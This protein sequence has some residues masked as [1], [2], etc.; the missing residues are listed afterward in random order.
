[1]KKIIILI[2]HY[3][4]LDGLKS[5][6]MSIRE[7]FQ[8]DVLIVDDG[9]QVKPNEEELKSIYNNGNLFLEL[10]PENLGVGLATNHGL[11]KITSWEYELTGRLDCGDKVYPNKFAQQINYLKENPDVKLLGTWVNMVDMEGNLLFTLKH[12]ITYPEIKKKI[13]LNS[14]FVNSSVI[15][16]TSILEEIGLF[17]EEYQ[18]NGEDYAF[19]FNV[20]ERF[21]CENL[22]EVLLD[23]EVN[24][25]SL[26]SLGR[27]DQVTARINI[28]KEKFKWGFY[29]IYGLVRSYIL[30]YISRDT[31]TFF[32]KFLHKK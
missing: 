23:Y 1:M 25:N 3:N 14:T 20:I 27:K 6:L 12:P 5:S 30:L 15:Y 16:Y 17:P 31:T 7:D 9:S 26:S 21:K 29:P 4:N 18:Q 11:K 32:K 8:V 28:I 19:F 10:L 2:C 22:P 13:Y 24:P